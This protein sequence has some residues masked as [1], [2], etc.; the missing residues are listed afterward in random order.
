MDTGTEHSLTTIVINVCRLKK[1]TYEITNC[2]E[3][4]ANVR[5]TFEIMSNS[6]GSWGPGGYLYITGHDLPQAYVM[7]LPKIGH[8]M[9]LVAVVDVPDIAGQGIA[10]DHWACT[11]TLVGIYRPDKTVIV[12]EMP[13]EDEIMAVARPQR[14][15]TVHDN[16]ADFHS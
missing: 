10:W 14:T 13:T 5:E 12:T 6:G 3:I 2:Y 9:H 4:P 8:I 11:P 15:G 1:D 7:E 16:V